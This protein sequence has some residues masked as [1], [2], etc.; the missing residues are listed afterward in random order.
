MKLSPAGLQA[1][2]LREG[3][4]LNAYLDSR[5]IPTIGVGHTGPEVRMGL[6]W[7]NTQVDEALAADVGWAEDEVNRMVTVPMTQN[8]F[9]A[10]VSFV[11]N[12]GKSG[13]DHS[14]ALRDFNYAVTKAANDLLMWETP[15]ILK[16]RRESERQQFLLKDA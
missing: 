9:D 13:F 15:P 1:L 10:L 16:A 12:I 6:I 14:S 11:F 2:S 5:G 7:S 8:Q 3:R 4:R